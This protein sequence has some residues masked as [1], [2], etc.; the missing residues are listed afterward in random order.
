MIYAVFTS[1]AMSWESI[2]RNS[3]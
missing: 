1:M 3:W 2:Q